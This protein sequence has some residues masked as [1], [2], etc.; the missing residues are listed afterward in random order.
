MVYEKKDL[1]TRS[2]LKTAHRL[3]LLNWPARLIRGL[4]SHSSTDKLGSQAAVIAR[5]PVLPPQ[6]ALST[7]ER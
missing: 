5:S 1:A 3:S 4:K 6:Q 2:L 7:F